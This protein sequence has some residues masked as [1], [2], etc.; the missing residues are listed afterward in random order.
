ML[1]DSLR[2]ASARV[3]VVVT[4]HSAELLDDDELD[5]DSVLPAIAEGGTT[6]IGPLDEVSRSVLRDRLYTVG[7]LMRITQV[8]PE[9]GTTGDMAHLGRL[10]DEP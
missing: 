10:F 7:E 8:T 3:Q 4:S 1:R 6:R 9:E 5:P 2:D